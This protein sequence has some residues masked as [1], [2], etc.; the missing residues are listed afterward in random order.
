MGVLR[1]GKQMIDILF[2]QTIVE[3]QALT[4]TSAMSWQSTWYLSQTSQ[5]F[6]LWPLYHCARPTDCPL[7]F[8]KLPLQDSDI[9]F[10]QDDVRHVHVESTAYRHLPAFLNNGGYPP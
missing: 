2:K 1:F 3:P 4:D 7:P 9:Q 5:E 10:R 8:L 6:V